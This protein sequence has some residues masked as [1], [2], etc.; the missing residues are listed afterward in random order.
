MARAKDAK[1]AIVTGAMAV[2]AFAF[3]ATTKASANSDLTTVTGALVDGSD[4]MKVNAITII[5]ACIAIIIVVFGISWLIG[6]WKR[7]MNKA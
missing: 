7:K 5:T 1:K 2:G 4:D 3:A 6:I